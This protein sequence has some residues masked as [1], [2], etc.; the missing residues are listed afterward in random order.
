M[1]QQLTAE[2]WNRTLLERQHL[3]ERVEE[4]AI[5]VIDRCVGLQ[6]QNPQAPFFALTSRV[7]GFDPAELDG[8]LTDREVVRMVLQ[9]GT[10]FAMD[11]LDARWIRAAVQP[12]L[13]SGLRT[14]LT[15]LGDVDPDA[16]VET[17]RGAFADAGESGIAAGKLRSVLTAEW[18][19]AD[20]DSLAAVVRTRLP[21]V[22]VPPRGL[23]RRSGGP[24][25]A[26]L[27]EWIGPGE[28]AVSGDEALKDLIR[29]Y[30]RGFGPSSA[31]ALAAW[32][33]LT[34]LGP[35]LKA[36]D[37]DWELVTLTGPDGQTLYDLEGLSIADPGVTPPVRLVAPYDGVLVANA[38]RARVADPD[39][40]RATVTP[41]GISP[42]FVLVEGRLAGTW[43]LTD[44]GCELTELVDLDSRQ[45]A[46]V[47]REAAA[48]AE[49]A[50]R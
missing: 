20:P 32:S 44:A 4:D 11:A 40:F 27:D 24:V 6:A 29:M 3:L 12:A 17:A 26:L 25:L 10:L 1:A 36:M 13:E 30:L 15:G 49:F 47:E 43:R 16:V 21:L 18:P 33:G 8:L 28:P 45:R 41:N 50:A 42:G 19:S 48:V 46:E 35:L 37:A 31:A 2:Q 23:W 38:D 22:Q 34:G 5:E 14:H 7:A 9:R 39:I